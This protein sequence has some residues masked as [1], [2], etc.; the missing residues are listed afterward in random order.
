MSNLNSILEKMQNTKICD[1]TNPL[2]NQNLNTSINKE[3]IV[4]LCTDCGQYHEKSSNQSP[5]NLH[6]EKIVYLCEDCGEYHSVSSDD[7]S[8][9]SS[10]SS[11]EAEGN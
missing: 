9:S 7:S 6:K 11:M 10:I 4:Y 8:D 5:D 3:K 2:F 1:E